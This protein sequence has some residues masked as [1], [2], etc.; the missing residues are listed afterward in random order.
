MNSQRHA[1]AHDSHATN[2]TSHAI[3]SYGLPSNLTHAMH[4]M[5]LILV[6]TEKMRKAEQSEI[7]PMHPARISYLDC[8]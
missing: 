6:N 4:T 8:L 5:L 1:I 7:P 2:T 3:K